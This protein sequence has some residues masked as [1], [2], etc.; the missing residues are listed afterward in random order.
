MVLFAA[1]LSAQVLE[2]ADA[3]V[4]N[5]YDS[6]LR[7]NFWQ[8]GSNPVG[9]RQDRSLEKISYA[10]F[11]GSLAAGGFRQSHEA[12]MPWNAGVRAHTLVHLEKFSMQGSFSFDQMQGNDMCGSIFV[13][14]GYYPI[15]ALEFTPGRKVKQTY[16]FDGSISVDIA[17]HWR[18]GA[19]MDFT[20]ANLSKRKDVRHSNYLLD[21]TVTPGILWHGEKWAVGM[22]AILRKTADTPT[23]KQIGTKETYTA[24]LDK[25]LY[26]GRLEDWQ[27]S[28]LHLA[29]A[30]VSGMPVKE[31]FG[32]AA[33]QVQHGNAFVEAGY[34][35][36]KGTIGE[37]QYVW[38]RFPSHN[39]TF[40][41]G[42]KWVRGAYTHSVRFDADWRW[43]TNNE[44]V[45]EKVTEG[46]VSTT[47]EHGSNQILS[48]RNISF[49]AEYS[50]KTDNDE[51][52][53]KGGADER[54]SSASQMYPFVVDQDIV[55]WH[56]SAGYT[57]HIGKL[58]VAAGLG[59]VGGKCTEA[60]RSVNEDSG[61]VTEMERL[62]DYYKMDVEYRTAPRVNIGATVSYDF[63][64][65]LYV[66]AAADYTRAF[67]ITVLPGADRVTATLS[68]GYNF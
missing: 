18:A 43:L 51:F 41:F 42:D 50:F 20:S 28:G 60:E 61:V 10:E 21:M 44:T 36:G 30:G 13:N 16:S 27:G 46:G 67:N 6:A 59:Y 55:Q 11:Y 38:Y 48:R 1:P 65:G 62:E 52:V 31:I 39:L 25:G 54:V 17:D 29:E 23:A 5:R 12:S 4:F 64:K 15:D 7:E 49:R 34:Q 37:K 58:D 53:V 9:M 47:V 3:V 68:L 35:Y 24:F 56:V 63:W 26:Y 57:R 2:G 22:N 45:I 66:K 32:G 14:P 19:G 33:L 40:N 8:D